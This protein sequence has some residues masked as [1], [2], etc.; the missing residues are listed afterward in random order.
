MK[1]VLKTF[2]KKYWKVSLGLIALNSVLL[3]YNF[4][5]EKV[6]TGKHAKY[7]IPLI[8]IQIVA[9][10]GLVVLYNFLKKKNWK[11]ERIFLALAGILGL[12]HVFLTPMNQLPDEIGHIFRAYAISEGKL[13]GEKDENGDYRSCISR[14]YWEVLNN[15]QGDS[16]Y[17]KKLKDNF[18]SKTSDELWCWSYSNTAGYHPVVYAPQVMGILVGKFLH[19]PIVLTMYLGRIFALIVFLILCFFAIKLVPKF[20]EFFV[21]FAFFPEMLQ[22]GMAYSADGLL[23]GSALLLTA[24]AFKYIYGDDKKLNKKQIASIYLLTTLVSICKKIIYLPLFLLFFLIPA[25]K[26]K[27]KWHKYL[28][29]AL[30]FALALVVNLSWMLTQESSVSANTENLSFVLA[31]LLRFLVMMVGTALGANPGYYAESGLGLNLAYGH[32]VPLVDIYLYL[33]LVLLVLLCVRN[34]EKIVLK[35]I[36]KYIYWLIPIIVIS[37]IYFVSFTQWQYTK[38]DEVIIE[39][40]QGRYFLPLVGLIPLIFCP[41]KSEKSKKPL[42]VDYVF[43][44]G[45]FINSCILA[46][47]FLH[48]F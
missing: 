1:E 14:T 35:R 39:G 9:E 24:L 31:N 37:L 6:D 18:L 23:I 11:I 25:N 44:F 40:T 47:K 16:E 20:K 48:N 29:L 34:S 12:A 8:L 22:Q 28:H 17:Y 27:K 21:F 13:I 38:T 36:E 26:F 7:L 19:L 45:I 32:Y 10:V 33:A 15:A 41:L 2:F 43:L 5:Y 42:S 3:A 30:S 4:L 46:M